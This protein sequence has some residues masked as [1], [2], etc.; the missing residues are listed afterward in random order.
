MREVSAVIIQLT[1]LN[2]ERFYINTDYIFKIESAPDTVLTFVTGEK[3]P[4][5]DSPEDIL[6]KLNGETL[7]PMTKPKR[8]EV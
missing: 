5:L 2:G 4:V 3:Q 6:K 8:L 1:K 7:L